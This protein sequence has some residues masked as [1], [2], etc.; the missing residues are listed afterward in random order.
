M[1]NNY[2]E[3]LEGRQRVPRAT[4]Y[5]RQ[6]HQVQNDFSDSSEDENWRVSNT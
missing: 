6:Q 1:R 4:A 2:R 3:Y 5:R